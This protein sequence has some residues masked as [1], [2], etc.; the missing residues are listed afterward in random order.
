MQAVLKNP[1]I[2]VIRPQGSLNAANALEFER[3]LTTALTKNSNSFLLVDL[4]QVES[5]D[6]AGLMALV[7]AL[8]LAQSLGQRF[9]LCSLSPSIRIIFEL[10]QLDRVFEILESQAV[11]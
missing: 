1:Q 3:N 5:L 9:S 7:S 8:K 2:T 10:T 6:S 11:L 4:E